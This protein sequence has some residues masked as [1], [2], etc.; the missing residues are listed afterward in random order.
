MHFLL[1]KQL[2]WE[3]KTEKTNKTHKKQK[4]H[5]NKTINNKM[6]HEQMSLIED[7]WG[8]SVSNNSHQPLIK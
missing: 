6:I 7:C 2:C 8:V 3:K 4:K 5:N 1:V